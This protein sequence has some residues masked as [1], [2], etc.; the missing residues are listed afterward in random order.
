MK[1][2][3]FLNKIFRN[4]LKEFSIIFTG[5]HHIWIWIREKHDHLVIRFATKYYVDFELREKLNLK[6]VKV[7]FH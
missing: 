5:K 7:N 3:I 4:F 1:E 6:I 2:I